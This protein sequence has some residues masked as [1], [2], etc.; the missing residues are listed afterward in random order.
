ML[1]HSHLAEGSLETGAQVDVSQIKLLLQLLRKKDHR[2]TSHTAHLAATSTESRRLLPQH[3]NSLGRMKGHFTVYGMQEPQPQFESHTHTHDAL[4]T[5]ARICSFS[6]SLS[7]RRLLLCVT[8]CTITTITTTQ[9][10]LLLL[11]A[12][13][14]TAFQLIHTSYPIPEQDNGPTSSRG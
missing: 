9:L 13:C 4:F 12:F 11:F 5:L 14:A 2:H 10:V 7:L 1:L 3:R 8:L 6:T